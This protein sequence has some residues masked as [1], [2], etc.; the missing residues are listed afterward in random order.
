MLDLTS[1]KVDPLKKRA[2]LSLSPFN[3]KPSHM[4]PKYLE[5]WHTLPRLPYKIEDYHLQIRDKLVLN[6]SCK[7]RTHEYLPLI[8]HF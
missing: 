8:L 1:S 6:S 4:P 3:P 7:E 2:V 5:H